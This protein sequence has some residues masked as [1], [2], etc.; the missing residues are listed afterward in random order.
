MGLEPHLHVSG[1][2]AS[3]KKLMIAG[4][5][6]LMGLCPQPEE[7]IIDSWCEP[8]DILPS[9]LQPEDWKWLKIRADRVWLR[10]AYQ[11][12]HQ[13]AKGQG[14]MP[15]DVVQYLLALSDEAEERWP[16]SD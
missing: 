4:M 14:S 5:G 16:T 8:F 10:G 6:S 13:V 9:R 12:W 11:A 2:A 1:G 7:W 15:M 3:L